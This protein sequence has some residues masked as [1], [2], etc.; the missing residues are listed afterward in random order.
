[1]AVQQFGNLFGVNI[2]VQFDL[3]F[4]IVRIELFRAFE[5]YVT[6]CFEALFAIVTIMEFLY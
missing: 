2:A 1:M 4:T 6:H 5:D 3:I